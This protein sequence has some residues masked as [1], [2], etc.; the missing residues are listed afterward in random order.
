MTV[1]DKTSEIYEIG[2]VNKKRYGSGYKVVGDRRDLCKYYKPYTFFRQKN[3]FWRAF[4]YCRKEKL[5]T[6][7]ENPDR[8]IIEAIIIRKKP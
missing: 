7:K 5:D 3:G 6:L 1:G 4:L 2:L 8:V